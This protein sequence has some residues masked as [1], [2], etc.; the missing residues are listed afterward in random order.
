MEASL[1]RSV[2]NSELHVEK[3][4][5]IFLTY[6][7]DGLVP[8]ALEE[9]EDGVI[10]Q[11]L[12]AN[13]FPGEQIIRK[14]KEDQYRF[15]INCASLGQLCEEYSFS[16]ALENLC[17]DINLKP[18]VL[19]RDTVYANA[20]FLAQ[21]KALAGSVLQPRYQFGDYLS[22]GQGLY[23]KNKVLA[24]LAKL[25][26][27]D[28]IE[29]YLWKAYHQLVKQNQLT[30]RLVSSRSILASR[31]AI[32]VLAV[33]LAGALAFGGYALFFALPQRTQ[34]IEASMA[35]IYGDPLA[36][37]RALAGVSVEQMSFDVKYVLARAY[38]L[39][40]AMSDAQKE[41][42]LVGLT[43]RTDG[44]IFEY[45]IALGRLDFDTAIDLAGRFHDN[46]LL[47]FAY[48]KN[49][50]FVRNDTSLSGE[51]RSQTLRDLERRINE[52]NQARETANAQ[53]NEAGGQ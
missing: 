9:T 22:G 15:L 31:I 32:P 25:G 36:V 7:A 3:G 28:E 34:V 44:A 18:Q 17:M 10:F 38:V 23:K 52:L 1:Q 11:F 39:T 33:L 12:T 4:K 50:V 51:E 2:R 49:E 43:Q 53:L 35:Y 46:E 14:S 20:D 40:E 16:L 19:V 8:C 48:M 21:Y 29:N 13:L 42:I 24:A 30:K 5:R 26:T 27:I 47:L 6:P 41:N 45:W 37:Q